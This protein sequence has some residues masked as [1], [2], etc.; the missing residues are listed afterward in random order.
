MNAL[1]RRSELATR[2]LARRTVSLCVPALSILALAGASEASS[3]L[4]GS[5]IEDAQSAFTEGLAAGSQLESQLDARFFT[6][7]WSALE[8]PGLR[9]YRVVASADPHGRV[10]PTELVLVAGTGRSA[11]SSAFSY[12][13]TLPLRPG[14]EGDLYVRLEAIGRDGAA[15]PVAQVRTH[16]DA[17]PS[18]RL[19]DGRAWR[20]QGNDRTSRSQVTRSAPRLSPGVE[21]DGPGRVRQASA[22][23]SPD[24]ATRE[25]ARSDRPRGPPAPGV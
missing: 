25:R 6:V 16:T 2:R 18:A 3:A 21:C 12:R 22:P 17:L 7:R 15:L 1:G 24:P 11:G 8:R 9:G 20:E 5:P 4:P 14:P 19:A 10:R 13:V 23:E